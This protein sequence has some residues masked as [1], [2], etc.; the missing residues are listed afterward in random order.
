MYI[1]NIRITKTHD[2][3]LF[4]KSDISKKSKRER[5]P[6]LLD[7][8]LEKRMVFLNLSASEHKN[9]IS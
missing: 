1:V 4:V 2:L 6:N 9:I 8:I 3:L 5:G 7:K